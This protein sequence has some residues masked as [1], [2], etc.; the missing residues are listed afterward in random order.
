MRRKDREVTE[1]EEI[2]RILDSAKIVRL[3]LFDG[4]FPYVVP[5]HCGYEFVNDKLVLYMHSAPEGHK[6]DVIRTDGR[7]CAEL[8][9]DAELIPAGDDACRYGSSFASVIGRGRAVIVEDAAEKIHG[10]ELLM[11]HQTGR[12]FAFTEPMAA[13]VAVIRVDLYEITAKRKKKPM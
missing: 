11:R 7:C 6:L 8:D 4:A 9:C 13:C 12:T 1:Q 10:L 2:V 3:G 5:L